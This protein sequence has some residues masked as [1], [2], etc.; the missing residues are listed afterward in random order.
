MADSDIIKS[1]ETM[2]KS[3]INALVEK[4]KKDSADREML[5]EMQSDL[6]KQIIERLGGIE[7]SVKI[8]KL[9]NGIKPPQRK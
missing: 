3:Q 5:L 1:Q 9:A 2:A 7:S 6:S 8:M 4:G